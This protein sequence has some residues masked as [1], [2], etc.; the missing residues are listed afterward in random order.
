MLTKEP[1]KL[2]DVVSSYKY[3]FTVDKHAVVLINLTNLKT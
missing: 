3:L 1:D 2:G